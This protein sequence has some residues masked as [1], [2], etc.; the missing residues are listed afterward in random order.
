MSIAVSSLH[1]SRVLM[2]VDTRV[3]ATLVFWPISW[4]NRVVPIMT[5]KRSVA[6]ILHE[7]AVRKTT[8]T[9]VFKTAHLATVINTVQAE[10]RFHP[11]PSAGTVLS[12]P[13]NDST[14]FFEEQRM[15]TTQP[16]QYPTSSW[17]ER[18][19]DHHTAKAHP[20]P[21]ISILA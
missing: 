8:R 19:S 6:K 21:G 7:D 3:A 1:R 18:N 20:N 10:N 4:P 16:S 5:S 17:S 13:I 2:Q 11:L 14:R 12:T 15:L 9:S